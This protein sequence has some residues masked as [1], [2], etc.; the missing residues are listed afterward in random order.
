MSDTKTA[1]VT[2]G[3]R[4][5]GRAIALAL[6]EDGYGV[7]GLHYAG[8]E[9]AA[10]ETA[11]EIEKKGATPLLLRRAFGD[12]TVA[13]AKALA[14]DFLDKV[15]GETGERRVHALVN[16]AGIGE[17]QGLGEIDEETYRRVVDVN[18]TAPLFL[19]QELAPQL[20]DGSGR[21]VN[22]STGFTRIAAPTHVA[23][24]ASKG[25]LNTLTLALA[26]VLGRRN[27]TVNAVMPGVIETDMNAG[28]LG[29]PEARAG[30]EAYSVFGRIGQP[31]EVAELVAY[32]ASERSRWTTGQILDATGGSAL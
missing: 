6:A 22:I 27:I 29:D 9:D 3:T 26:P 24:A 12:D 23:Y 21:V 7:V 31:E 16:N 13:A 32:L 15:E 30:A 10:R 2:G 14:A 8:N 4:G 19:T 25:A 1:L 5:I 28:W 17:P 11:R 20:A 18:L